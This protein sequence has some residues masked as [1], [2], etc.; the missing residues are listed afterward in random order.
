MAKTKKPQADT[1]A[2]TGFDAP[3]AMM[4]MISANP[5]LAKAW[6]DMMSE[7]ARFMT[8][9]LRTDMETQKA[10]MACKTPA[11]LVEVQAAFLTTAMEQYSDEAARM[12]DMTMKASQDIA[13]DLKSGHSRGYDDVPV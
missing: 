1:G 6:M 4:T 9:R 11:E 13:E 8:E 5:V 10:F 2:D 12:L 7:S 3:A